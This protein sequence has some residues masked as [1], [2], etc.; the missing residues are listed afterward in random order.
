MLYNAEKQASLQISG[1]NPATP[2]TYQTHQYSKGNTETKLWVQKEVAARLSA[3]TSLPLS[4]SISALLE[5]PLPNNT[6]L[7][8]WQKKKEKETKTACP[9]H[10]HTR[11]LL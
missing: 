9:I 8:F 1:M 5:R 3:H 10:L 6:G 2:C 11:V 4:D 7:E